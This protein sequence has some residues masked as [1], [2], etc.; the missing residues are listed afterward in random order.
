M[1]AMTARICTRRRWPRP[2]R[3]SGWRDVHP[4]QAR[5]DVPARP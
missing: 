3:R 1:T 2:G 4:G 5:Q